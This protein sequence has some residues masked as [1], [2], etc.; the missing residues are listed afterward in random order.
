MLSRHNA[1]ALRLAILNEMQVRAATPK[2][3]FVEDAVATV[4][5]VDYTE[6]LKKLGELRDSGI[7]T[8]EEFP[9]KK[10]ENL[11]KI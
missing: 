1:A 11:K 3:I 5:A 6:Q 7:L 10:S 2:E 4:A 8:E 9:A